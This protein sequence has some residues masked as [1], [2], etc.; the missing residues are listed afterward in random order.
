MK[1]NDYEVKLKLM[2]AISNSSFI[3]THNKRAIAIQLAMP[4]NRVNS[5]VNGSFINFNC[6]AL[7]QVLRKLEFTV[8][9]D[10][11]PTVKENDRVCSTEYYEIWIDDHIIDTTNFVGMARLKH[12][13]A[14]M[15]AS[16]DRVKLIKRFNEPGSTF[17]HTALL[18][19]NYDNTWLPM[20]NGVLKSA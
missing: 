18:F 2:S 3:K 13:H 10:I 11:K 14:I 16:P 8:L 4:M 17:Q 20:D 1:A 12:N 19:N 5:I 6:D 15:L 9:I 7:I